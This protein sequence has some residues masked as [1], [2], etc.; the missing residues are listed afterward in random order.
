V[1]R[2]QAIVFLEPS[3]LSDIREDVPLLLRGTLQQRARTIAGASMLFD[4]YLERECASGRAQ[5]SL[6]PGPS[7]VLLHSHCHQRAMGLSA[8]ALALLS[9]IPGAAVTDLDAGC[10]GMAGSFGYA[11]EHYDVSRAIG[12]LKLFPAARALAAD[13]A[14]VAAGTSCRHQVAQ[15]TDVKA[16]HPAVLLRALLKAER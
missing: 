6:S 10:C 16:V 13:G 4:E 11:K 8:S 14:L 1:S 15:F 9:R 12:E 3:C 5:L 2:G 7:S